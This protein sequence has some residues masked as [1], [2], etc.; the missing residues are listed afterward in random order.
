M[1]PHEDNDI[2]EVCTHFGADLDIGHAFRQQF[3][4]LEHG[5]YMAS[6]AI[7]SYGS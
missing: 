3:K 4:I 2:V 1:Q 7:Q 5:Q 6:M